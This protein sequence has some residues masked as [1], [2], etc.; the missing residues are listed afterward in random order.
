[1]IGNLGIVDGIPDDD[2]GS[3]SYLEL[4]EIRTVHQVLICDFKSPQKYKQITSYRER[5]VM[6]MR[7]AEE[8]RSTMASSVPIGNR[9]RV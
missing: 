9:R 3:E 6:S 2:I 5:D 1:M 4:H 7:H 8:G